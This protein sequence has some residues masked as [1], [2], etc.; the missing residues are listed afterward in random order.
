M[1]T[2]LNSMKRRNLLHV[3]AW[4]IIAVA[5]II[6][7][8][9]LRQYGQ[10]AVVRYDGYNTLA[11]AWNG[12]A[13]GNIAE[14]QRRAYEL[15]RTHPQFSS[16]IIDQFGQHLI[17]MPSLLEELFP[18]ANQALFGDSAHE[19][20]GEILAGDAGSAAT[21]IDSMI[22]NDTLPDT[23]LLWRARQAMRDGDVRAAHTVYLRY[24][25][26]NS[27]SRVAIS[28]G[29][30]LSGAS[31]EERVNVLLWWG[32]W[33]EAMALSASAPDANEQPIAHLC[34]G[35]AAELAGD[36]A[37]ARADYEAVVAQRPTNHLAL[38]RLTALLET[39][40]SAATPAD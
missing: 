38:L 40:E 31:L 16:E 29:V 39:L 25:K 24:W 1:T 9:I 21:R 34:D 36:P 6:V 19:I 26:R 4:C 5:A 15:A 27:A 13:N 17:A 12:Y 14:A 18:K 22:N 35:I 7:L 11:A 2:V 10:A 8:A 32:L 33:D 3:A 23:V 37:K 30:I 28:E 20:V